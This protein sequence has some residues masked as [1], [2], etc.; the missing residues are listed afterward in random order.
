MVYLGA[1]YSERRGPL[2][3]FNIAFRVLVSLRN[4]LR[5]GVVSVMFVFVRITYVQRHAEKV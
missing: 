1:H 4:F 2:V 5:T 3:V